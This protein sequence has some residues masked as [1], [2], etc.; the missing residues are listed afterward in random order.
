MENKIVDDAEYL[1]DGEWKPIKVVNLKKGMIFRV[2]ELGL[3]ESKAASD[4]YLNDEGI[5]TVTIDF[6]DY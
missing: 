2:P 6:E 4:T 1:D 3:G 5:Y